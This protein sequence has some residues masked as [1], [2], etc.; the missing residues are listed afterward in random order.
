[1]SVSQT[2]FRPTPAASQHA[3]AARTAAYPRIRYA[4]CW[5]DADILLEA[6]SVQAGDV[7]LSIA[8][9]GENSL[10]LLSQSPSKVIAVDCNPS[11]LAILE[12]KAA[13]FRNLSHEEL[14]RFLGSH[15]ATAAERRQTYTYCAPDLA[16]PAA[17][18][19][20]ENVHLIETGINNAGKFE[21][22]FKLFRQTLL[23]LIHD[24][25]TVE[26]LC[27]SRS[28][29]ARRRFYL[30]V[31]NTWRWRALFSMFF[32]RK[33]MGNAGR[34]PALFKYVEGDCSSR[35]F[36]RVRHG[37]TEVPPESNPY[38]QWILFGEHRSDVL[39]HALREENFQSIR[40]NL[41]KLEWHCQTIEEYLAAN[42]TTQVDCFNLSDIFEYMS[43][44][45]YTELLETLIGS[46]ANGARMA[47][48]NMLVDRHAPAAYA[49]RITA[50]EHK[51]QDL[52]AADKAFFYSN[53]RL[54]TVHR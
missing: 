29:E 36:G 17:R 8:S 11:Q 25:R 38:L 2:V 22:Y 23:P 46:S 53:F 7:C 52:L 4:Q 50:D 27:A 14:L 34:D 13:A 43:A 16:P 37:L 1:M 19:F 26:Q 45:E 31:W 5:E 39:P 54:E 10:S 48:W 9:G 41:S 12:L 44:P 15:P 40:G 42:P 47:Y 6:L 3:Q 33:V 21:D 49:G 24:R 20:R 18:Y 30:E 51:A 28:L 32:S 35:I